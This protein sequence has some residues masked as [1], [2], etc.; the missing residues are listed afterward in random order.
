MINQNEQRKSMVS[1]ALAL[2]ALLLLY[3]AV[4]ATAINIVSSSSLLVNVITS[5]VAINMLNVALTALFTYIIVLKRDE[6]YSIDQGSV[7]LKDN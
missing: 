2:V 6:R 5:I 3:S 4:S 7:S 1:G